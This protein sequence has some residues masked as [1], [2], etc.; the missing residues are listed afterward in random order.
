MFRLVFKLVVL[1]QLSF[2]IFSITVNAD[3]E[4]DT[5]LQ[6]QMSKMLSDNYYDDM[7]SIWEAVNDYYYAYDD[8]ET[9]STPACQN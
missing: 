8:W 3:T 7:V 6:E 1:L 4:Q 2:M 5:P 9:D